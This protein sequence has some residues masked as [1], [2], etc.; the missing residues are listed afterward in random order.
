[1]IK[2]IPPEIA[3]FR[4]TQEQFTKSQNYSFDKL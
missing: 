2:Q 1:M 3:R 4:V